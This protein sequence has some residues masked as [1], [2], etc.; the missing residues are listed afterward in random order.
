LASYARILFHWTSD[1]YVELDFFHRITPHLVG[2]REKFTTY[3]LS[4]A[5]GFRSIY[6]WRLLELLERFK[7][8]GWAQYS[9]DELRVALELPASLSD[10]GQINRRA[11]TPAIKELIGKDNWAIQNPIPIKTGKRVT[12][13]R[14]E[15]DRRL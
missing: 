8:T 6:A 11:I 1:P 5:T 14:F 12:S 9:I 3:K 10:W 15:F 4:Q 2:L 7:S 13:I